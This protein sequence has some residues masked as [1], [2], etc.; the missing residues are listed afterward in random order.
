[1][2]RKILYSFVFKI[3]FFILKGL[4]VNRVGAYSIFSPPVSSTKRKLTCF[5]PRESPKWKTRE[6]YSGHYQPQEKDMSV[7]FHYLESIGANISLA[8]IKSFQDR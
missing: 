1:M 8:K 7:V 4:S 3:F 6:V 2:K 5:C